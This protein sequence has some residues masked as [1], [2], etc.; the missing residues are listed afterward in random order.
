MILSTLNSHEETKQINA[1]LYEKNG[2]RMK[3]WILYGSPLRSEDR[4]WVPRGKVLELANFVG[5]SEGGGGRSPIHG[6]TIGFEFVWG[7]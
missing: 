1:N 5:G 7:S 6:N 4:A 3:K 2:F